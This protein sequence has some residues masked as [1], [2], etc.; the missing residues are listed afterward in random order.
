MGHQ[1]RASS[2]LNFKL[3]KRAF[4]V[5]RRYDPPDDRGYWHSRTPAERLQAVEFYRQINFGA[6]REGRIQ[7]LIEVVPIKLG[8]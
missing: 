5:A 8:H 6:A 1:N 2:M 3:D 7:K 4:I